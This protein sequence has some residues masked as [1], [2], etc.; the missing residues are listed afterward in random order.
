M[1]SRQDFDVVVATGGLGSG[2]FLA[3][4]GNAT[5]GREESRA[6]ELL[7]QR[8]YCKLHIVCHYVAKLLGP[9]FPVV[10]I[11][12]VGDD[13]AGR[14]VRTELARLG[15]DTDHVTGSA[16]PTLFSVCFL[17]P[18]GDGGNL[19]TSRSASSDVSGVD[20]QRAGPVL[21][22]YRDHGVALALPEVPLAARAELLRMGREYGFL[23]VAG[24]VTGEMAEVRDSGMLA[25]VD[26]LA[27]NVDEA[28]ALAGDSAPGSSPADDVGAAVR[29]L[30]RLSPRLS[31][32][33]TAGADGS[34]TWD[35]QRLEHAPALPVD[36]VNTAGAGDAHLAAVVVGLVR[37]LDLATANSYAAVVSGLAVT[38]PHTINP[39]IDAASVAQAA[40]RHGR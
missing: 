14:A 10:P 30:T 13:D 36:V 21:E 15:I 26:L 7:D 6:A 24:V 23:R 1:S 3:L 33:V 9:S 29:E 18:D 38:S 5:L 22:R 8:D 40:E 25:D 39:E 28:R 12:R 34:W 20:V 35:G 11:G 19:T 16:R 2:I 4:E 17:Y 37:G 31:V 32:V 27:V